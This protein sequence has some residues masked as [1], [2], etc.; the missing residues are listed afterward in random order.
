[1]QGYFEGYAR[2]FVERDLA[3][4]ERHFAYPCLIVNQAGADM[5]HDADALQ[6]NLEGFFASLQEL[7]VTH[8]D[9]EVRDCAEPGPDHA[10]AT[11]TYT[12]K[13]ADGHTLDVF[14]F[15]YVLVKNRAGA[16]T[17]RLAELLD[18]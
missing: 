12:L 15:L 14:A 7:D 9:A 1:M 2:A 13:D 4:I 16:W 18:A 6:Q 5:I 3:R 10:T 8:I 17:I 11:V